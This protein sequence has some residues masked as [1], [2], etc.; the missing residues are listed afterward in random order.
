M[1]IFLDSANLD[2]IRRWLAFG[3]VDGV[4]TN[5]TILLKDGG[6]SVERRTRE[7]AALVAPRPVCVEVVGNDHAEMLAQARAFARWEPNIV[8][9]VPVINE[10]GQ[11][12]LHIVKALVEEGVAVN[13]T[14]C[15]S[16]GQVA[17]S[18]KVGAAYASIF[19]GRVADEGH[20]APGLIRQVTQWLS[21][22][23]Y[24]TQIIAGSIRE[25]IN[26]Q[27]IALAGVHIITTPPQFLDKLVD[28]HYTRATVRQFNQDAERAL[29]QADRERALVGK[30]PV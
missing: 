26:I 20:D 6:F 1:R 25:P 8:V 19:T 29:S 14:A 12:S 22:W 10:Q 30:P 27:E 15:L 11:P 13:V 9:K 16:F 23:G 28:H 3:V 21:A 4:T 5:P 24:S 7:I 2:E 18:A 17:L